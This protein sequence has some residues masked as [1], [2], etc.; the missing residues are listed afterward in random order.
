MP[1]SCPTHNPYPSDRRE[2]S[3]ASS[4]ARRDDDWVRF[5]NS[6]TWRKLSKIHLDNSPYCIDHLE[7]GEH[8]PAVEVHHTEGT[9]P[10]YALDE[11][12]LMSLCKACHS[13]RTAAAMGKPQP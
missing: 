11:S 12:T 9:N 13:R 4:R 5:I 7:R 3:R 8:V 1:M 2:R 10:E 6:P